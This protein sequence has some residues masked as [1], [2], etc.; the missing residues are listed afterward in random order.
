[1][2][3][4]ILKTPISDED[5]KDIKLNGEFKAGTYAGVQSYCP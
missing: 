4:K 5:L 1:M 2:A 3:K